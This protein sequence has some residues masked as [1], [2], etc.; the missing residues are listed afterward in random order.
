M[1][2]LIFTAFAAVTLAMVFSCG[3]SPK[4]DLRDDVDTLSYAIG[5]AQSQG[6]REYLYN[7]GLD[8]TDMDEFYKG[9]NVGINAGDNTKKTAY[10]VGNQIGQQ[11]VNQMIPN[12][13]SQLFGTDSTQTISLKNFLAGFINGSSNK[14]TLMSPMEAQTVAQIKSEIIREKSMEKQFA[15][16]KLEGEKFLASY[17]KND[18]VKKL[19]GGVL[20]KVIKE[21][22]GAIPTDSSTVIVNYEGKTIDG[23]VFDSSYERGEAAKLRANQVI[24]GWTEALKHMPVGSEWEVVIPQELAYGSNGDRRKIKP[25]SALIFKIELTGIEK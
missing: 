2:K 6:L 8:S 20:Y 9:L 11:I 5:L 7:M 17:A 1:K 12:I 25:F 18:S 13:N 21:G 24:K 15:D 19:D 23:E 4:A 16:N 22:H 14:N 3:N 10:F